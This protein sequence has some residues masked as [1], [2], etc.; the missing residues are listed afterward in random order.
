MSGVDVDGLDDLLGRLDH[1]RAGLLDL[2]DA[3]R[4][5]AQVV[6]READSRTPT[7]T[8]GL[9]NNN[10]AVA[11]AT[12]WGATNGE[13]Y[14]GYVHWGTRYMTARPWLLEAAR[15]TEDTWMDLATDHV[16]RLLDGN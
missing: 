15:A 6:V 2:T 8:G 9:H 1:A 13:P 12:G 3:N 11:T 7:A 5:M 10:R 14:A 4:D 16:Q